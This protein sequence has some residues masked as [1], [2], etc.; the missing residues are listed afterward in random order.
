[1]NELI[2]LIMLVVKKC[3]W[4][5]SSVKKLFDTQENRSSRCLESRGPYASYIEMSCYD[6]HESQTDVPSTCLW[7]AFRIAFSKNFPSRT[8]GLSDVHT[9]VILGPYSLG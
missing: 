7:T 1:M 6:V 8:G 9:E 2:N 3:N 5:P 4:V